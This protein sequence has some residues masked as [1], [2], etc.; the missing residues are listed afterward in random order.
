MKDHLLLMASLGVTTLVMAWLPSVSKKI[1]ISY[2]I[3]LLGIGVFLYYLGLPMPMSNL[4]DIDKQLMYFCEI[5]VII[6]LMGAG[7][8]IGNDYRLKSWE[9]PFRL[10]VFTMPLTMIAIYFLGIHL[11]SLSLPAAILL[12]ATLVP[13]DPVLAA[14]VQIKDMEQKENSIASQFALTAEAGINDGVA[15]PFIFMAVLIAEAGG[16]NNFDLSNWLW[17][18]FLLKI[19]LGVL[20]GYLLGRS[21]GYL[22]E[23]LPEI[24]GI[25]NPHGFVAISITLM[26]YGITELLH[27]YGFLAVFIAALSIRYEEKIHNR[28]EE[29]MHHF[30][31]EV[32]R[33]LLVIWLILFGGFTLD[34]IFEY[35]DW[36]GILFALMLIFLIR[37]IS[38]MIG[39]WGVDR[40]ASDKLAI[41]FLGIRGI[42][43]FFYLA[44]AFTQTNLIQEKNELYA[45]TSLVVLCSII[46]HGLTAPRI[47]DKLVQQDNGKG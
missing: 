3:I 7:L 11:F 15:F 25:K 42:G 41:S 27:G 38:G 44:W 33:F 36:R 29:K 19:F 16:W 24:K 10:I 6:S 21:I 40:S 4:F 23:S 8:K 1:K 14:E 39:L 43:S 17:D 31:E 47:I 30:V 34:G 9:M 5:M 2:P 35:I 18:K 20:I 32:E 12:A 37:P 13:T 28:V 22:L 46:I 45:I 26:T